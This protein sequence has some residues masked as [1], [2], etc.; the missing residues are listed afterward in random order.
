M[1]L[2]SYFLLFFAIS[3]FVFHTIP[4]PSHSYSWFS[5]LLSVLLSSYPSFPRLLSSFRF[6]FLLFL[7]ISLLFF[8]LFYFP[9]VLIHVSPSFFLFFFPPIML[10]V[11]PFSFPAVLRHFLFFI[12]FLFL[13]ILI[14]ASPFFSL[15][16]FPSILLLIICGSPRASPGVPCRNLLSFGFPCFILPSLLFLPFS[17]LP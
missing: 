12:P 3:L 8:I 2:L 9:H 17:Y 11:P 4:L 10:R 5:F 16:F 6:S 13:P 14:H 7:A 1:S 15:F